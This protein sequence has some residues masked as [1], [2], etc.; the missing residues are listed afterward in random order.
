MSALRHRCA[1]SIHA[2]LAARRSRDAAESAP[3]DAIELEHATYCRSQG[4]LLRYPH[5]VLRTIR[6]VER[7]A[8]LDLRGEPSDDVSYVRLLAL[9]PTVLYD[10][11]VCREHVERE[12]AQREQGEAL[13]RDLRSP[14]AAHVPDAGIRCARCKSSDIAFDFLQTRSADEGTTVYCTCTGC[15]KRWKM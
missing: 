7:G 11:L 3:A 15:C 6:L 5:E 13:L 1:W 14:D 12:K 10:T 8:L 9:S 2:S 4:C